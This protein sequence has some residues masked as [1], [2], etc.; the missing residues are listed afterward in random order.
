MP[1]IKLEDDA[2]KT[3]INYRWDG[4]IRQLKNIAEE[5]SVLEEDRSISNKTLKNYLPK[6]ADSSLPAI[7]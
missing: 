1:S 4:N 6:G 7:I 2:I 3:L 5:L